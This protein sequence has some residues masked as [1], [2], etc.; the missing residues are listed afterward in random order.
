MMAALRCWCRSFHIALPR[1]RFSGSRWNSPLQQ[2]RRSY[3]LRDDASQQSSGALEWHTKTAQNGG[4]IDTI[5]KAS[6]AMPF[7]L[8]VYGSIRGAQCTNTYGSQPL[9]RWRRKT[10]NEILCKLATFLGSRIPKVS[11]SFTEQIDGW[12]LLTSRHQL[13]SSLLG[14]SLTRRRRWSM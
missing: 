2:L 8:A 12:S 14:S 5:G 9:E 6:K 13:E 10:W 11:A 7:L 1:R 3:T 4:A